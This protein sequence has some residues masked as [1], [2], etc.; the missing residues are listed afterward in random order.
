MA[1]PWWVAALAALPVSAASPN[2]NR[3]AVGAAAW[4]LATAVEIAVF[5][6]ACGGA[7]VCAALHL[8]QRKPRDHNDAFNAVQFVQLSRSPQQKAADQE[9]ARALRNKAVAKTSKSNQT[10]MV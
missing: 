3:A 2:A 6:I 4:E 7:L 10:A 9:E 1:L 5:G 8:C